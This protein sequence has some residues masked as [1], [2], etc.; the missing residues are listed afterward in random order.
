MNIIRRQEP[1]TNLP[2]PMAWDPFRIMADMIRW[3]PFR[4]LTPLF[5][6]EEMKGLFNPDVDVKETENAY[7]FEADVPGIKEKDIEVSLTGNRLTMSG[8]REEEK[9]EEKETYFSTERTYGSFTRSFTLPAGTDPE[10]VMANLKD[11]VLVITVPKLPNAQPKK[12]PV[13]EGDKPVAKA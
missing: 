12:V 7:V 9:R 13:G 5:S 4:E 8:K 11:G 2:A 6:A 10:H 1:K 3:D